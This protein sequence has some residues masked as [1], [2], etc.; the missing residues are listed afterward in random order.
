[1][2]AIGL[3]AALPEATGTALIRTQQKLDSFE[4][5]VYKHDERC[6]RACRTCSK[7]ESAEMRFSACARCSRVYYCSRECVPAQ[8]L[9]VAQGRV[10][11]AR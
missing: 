10:Q 2:H 11:E 5:P 6:R 8:G 3:S 4:D 9:A 1:M 7:A